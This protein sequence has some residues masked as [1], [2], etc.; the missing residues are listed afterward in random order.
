MLKIYE[1]KRVVRIPEDTYRPQLNR[2]FL[3]DYEANKIATIC[4]QIY[5]RDNNIGILNAELELSSL[6]AFSIYLRTTTDPI[7]SIL[8]F[9]LPFL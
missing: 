7:S 1:S 4:S 3:L 9:P 2:M 6:N 8:D 5:S